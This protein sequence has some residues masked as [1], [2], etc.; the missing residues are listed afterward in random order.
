MLS[1]VEYLQG[2]LVPCREF[3]IGALL[4]PHAEREAV[5]DP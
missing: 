5:V 3:A 1:M 2:L 4:H